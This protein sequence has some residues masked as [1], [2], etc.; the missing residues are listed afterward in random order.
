MTNAKVVIQ[1]SLFLLIDIFSYIY[2]IPDEVD[3][4]E[5]IL[6]IEEWMI[7]LFAESTKNV[8]E[9][10]NIYSNILLSVD[11]ARWGIFIFR[12]GV[13]I[14]GIYLIIRGLADESE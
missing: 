9:T 5:L 11:I 1:G 12:I 4:A 7:K 13:L 8:P 6:N 2:N 10:Q 3:A 14:L